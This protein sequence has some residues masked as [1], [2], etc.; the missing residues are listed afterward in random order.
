LIGSS[1]EACRTYFAHF[2]RHWSHDPR[3]FDADLE[4]WVDNFML[5]GNLQGGFN[6]YVSANAARLAAMRGDS[7]KLASIATPTRV[8][9]GRHDP[10]LKAEWAA[11]LDET[12]SD[13]SVDFAEEAGHFVHYEQPDLAARE[14]AQFFSAH[15]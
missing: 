14:I 13:L 3:A 10:I 2:L 6:W 15:A 12:F 9:W 1:R 11:C 5:P 7:P 4:A 8:L